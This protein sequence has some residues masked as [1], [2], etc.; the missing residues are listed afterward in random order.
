VE[1]AGPQPGALTPRKLN[2]NN[3]F[4]RIKRQPHKHQENRKIGRKMLDQLIPI[5]TRYWK[6]VFLNLS[7]LWLKIEWVAKTD[8]VDP[9]FFQIENCLHKLTLKAHTITE[10]CICHWKFRQAVDQCGMFIRV[11]TESGA[12]LFQIHNSAFPD[13]LFLLVGTLNLGNRLEFQSKTV[14]KLVDLAKALVLYRSE[15]EVH[16]FPH[17]LPATLVD[18]LISLRNSYIFTFSFV[19]INQIAYLDDIVST[20]KLTC[21]M[22]VVHWKYGKILSKND[23]PYH[24]NCMDW[25]GWIAGA[26]NPAKMHALRQ[27]VH[28][29]RIPSESNMDDD[30]SDEDEVE[31]LV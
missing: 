13:V 5:T 30:T 27:L 8:L 28:Q 19:Y 29:N 7:S 11:K 23:S 3:F 25:S 15:T 14:P 1:G 22:G 6:I 21:D 17:M 2:K 10:A 20:T 9:H 18:S 16:L 24:P 26:P 4:T 12:Y 31:P